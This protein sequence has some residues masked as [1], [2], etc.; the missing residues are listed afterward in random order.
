MIPKIVHHTTKN[1][2]LDYYEQ[3]LLFKNKKMLKGWEFKIWS[4][5]DN[6]E[7]VKNEFPQYLDVYDSI[8][9]GVAKSDIARCMY[10]YCCGGFYFD[11]DYEIIKQFS[12]D[13]LYK[14]CVLPVSR[15]QND[16]VYLGNCVFLSDRKSVV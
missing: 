12:D 4:D 9:K 6:R 2:L 16:N 1:G 15:I 13:F 3:K 5:E 7:L 10:M 11:T 8:N 14:K